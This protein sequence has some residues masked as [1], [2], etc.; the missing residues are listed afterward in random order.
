MTAVPESKSFDWGEIRR[1]IEETS[2]GAGGAVDAD[3]ERK[4][5]AERARAL[6]RRV[7][8]EDRGET[9]QVVEF[10]LASE[11]F[12][13]EMS[14][15]REV[16]PLRDLVQVPCTPGFIRGIVNVRGRLISVTDLKTFFDLPNEGLGEMNRIIIVAAGGME[17]GILAD[18][19]R[20]SGRCR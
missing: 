5:L 14:F 20:G 6:A 15:V 2:K 4:I 19:W 18:R 3:T 1:R 10:S 11:R 16:Y 13:I 12:G 9:L 8:G 17:T 7:E